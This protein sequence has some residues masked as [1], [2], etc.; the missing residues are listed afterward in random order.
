MFDWATGGPCGPRLEV[1][2]CRA[3]CRVMGL[4]VLDSTDMATEAGLRADL[5]HPRAPLML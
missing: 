3:I 5:K 4:N 1:L 2:G